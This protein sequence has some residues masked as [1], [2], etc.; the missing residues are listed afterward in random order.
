MPPSLFAFSSPSAN[1]IIIAS[2]ASRLHRRLCRRRVPSRPPLLP[3]RPAR[4]GDPPSPLP[5]PIFSRPQADS[6]PV[7]PRAQLRI[8]TGLVQ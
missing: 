3:K 2:Q 5:H 7:N 1:L 4:G 8:L 6:V